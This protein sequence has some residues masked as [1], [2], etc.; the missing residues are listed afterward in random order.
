MGLVA[1][2]SSH[3]SKPFLRLDLGTRCSLRWRNNAEREVVWTVAPAHAIADGVPPAFVIPEHEMYGEYFDIPP[4]EELVFISSFAGGEVFSERLLLDS[5]QRQDLLFQSRPRDVSRLP[6]RR[7]TLLRRM[8]S[9]GRANSRR[10]STR[11]RPRSHPR[12]G[13][14]KRRL[15]GAD[16]GGA[17][18][19]FGERRVIDR[20]N[21]R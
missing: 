18:T 15:E 14:R 19:P 2:H 3:Y 4:P 5:R 6:R 11:P 7:S 21:G 20:L 8:P 13:S 1:L 10:R 12:A 17:T 9:A 16:G